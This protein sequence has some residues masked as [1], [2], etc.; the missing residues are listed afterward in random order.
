MCYNRYYSY[1]SFVGVDVMRS[2]Y[3]K[4]RNI[5]ASFRDTDDAVVR[6]ARLIVAASDKGKGRTPAR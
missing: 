1:S 6:L 5:T 2:N 4:P 3:R